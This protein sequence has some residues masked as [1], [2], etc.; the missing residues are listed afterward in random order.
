VS[1]PLT[2]QTGSCDPW[3]SRLFLRYSSRSGM[4]Q[5]NILARPE[6]RASRSQLHSSGL[7]QGVGA[8]GEVVTPAGGNPAALRLCENGVGYRQSSPAPPPPQRQLVT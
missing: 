2:D 8:R 3:L 4:V 7:P 6:T 1:E 5:N